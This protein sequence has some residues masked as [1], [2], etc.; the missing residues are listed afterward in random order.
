MREGWSCKEAAH[1]LGIHPCKVP[2]ALD[3]ALTKIA[4][5]M[6]AD[7]L[8]TWG[9]LYVVM[10]RLEEERERDDTATP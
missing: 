4:K 1:V 10:K 6:L 8:K 5:L 9:D 7:P 2:Q 3:P